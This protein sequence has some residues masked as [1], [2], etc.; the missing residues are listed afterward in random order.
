MEN[1]IWGVIELGDGK[2][3]FRQLGDLNL[4]FKYHNEEIWIAHCYTGDSRGERSAG[5]LPEDVRWSRWAHKNAYKSI[6]I[7]PA[8]SYLPLIVHSEY[9]LKVS[10]RTDIQVFCRV[11]LWISIMIAD[12]NYKLAEFPVHQLP[13]TWF[14]T[15]LEG[16]LCYHTTTK[17]RR[18]LSEVHPA[19]HLITC[20]VTIANRSNVTLNFEHF[21]FRV[22]RLGIFLHENTLWADETQI[23]YRG[24]GQNS[25]VVMTGKLPKGITQQ[26]Q[27]SKP[28]R[29]IQSSLATRTFK[30]FIED[31]LTLG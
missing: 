1:K 5:E 24:E 9:S 7:E 13:K 8:H 17:A 11:P 20:P 16:E 28:R 2:V 19:P 15:R 22:E 10:P 12:D 31:T 3:Q 18:N 21:C 14:G 23:T 30:H 6:R 27:L 4:W 29:K 26:M 25:D